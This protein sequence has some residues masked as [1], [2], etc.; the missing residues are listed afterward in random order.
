[1]AADYRD[2]THASLDILSAFQWQTIA[3]VFD[4]KIQLVSLC[5]DNCVGLSTQRTAFYTYI[6]SVQLD[7]RIYSW[8]NSKENYL[9][10]YADVTCTS[11]CK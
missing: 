1:M 5:N 2:F 9:I 10:F 4:G 3:I 11:G 6:M 8:F 7:D